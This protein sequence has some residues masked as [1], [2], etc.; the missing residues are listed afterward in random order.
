MPQRYWL[1]KCEP[2]AYT[3]ADLE[4]DRT[5][6][7]EGVRNY[8]ARNFMR[9]Q[10]Q[11]GDPVLFYASNADPSG[12]TGLARIARAGYPD[13][14]A[15]KKGHKYF[16]AASTPE[17]PLWYLVDIAFVERFPEVVPLETLKKTKGLEKMVVTQKGSRLSVQPVT[18]AE[19]DIVVRLGRRKG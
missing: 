16:D 4:R 10:M 1:M 15:W 14:F 6:T 18:K 12:V 5:T 11:V 3:I 9:D 8:Q 17:K 2:S 7:W 13:A 19:Y